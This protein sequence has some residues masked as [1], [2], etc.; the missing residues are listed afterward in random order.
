M[1]GELVQWPLIDNA[2]AKLEP[3][4]V[5]R[6]RDLF[7]VRNGARGCERFQAKAA[8]AGSPKTVPTCRWSYRLNGEDEAL[9]SI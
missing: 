7:S 4:F 6:V 5:D 1:V 8:H 3:E 2:L 9:G